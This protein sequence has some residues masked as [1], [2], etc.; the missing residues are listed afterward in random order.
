MRNPGAKWHRGK[1]ED[2]SATASL[3]CKILK[4]GQVKMSTPH[5]LRVIKPVQIYGL[6]T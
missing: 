3:Y 1:S 5:Y 2:M 4:S 6:D